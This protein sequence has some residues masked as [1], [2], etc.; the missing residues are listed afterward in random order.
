[1]SPRARAH[2]E[3]KDERQ[4]KN[5]PITAQIWGI[6]THHSY[7]MGIMGHG[8]VRISMSGRCSRVQGGRGMGEEART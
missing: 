4:D 8:N 6:K 5:Q 1:M 2:K 3:R 7:Q